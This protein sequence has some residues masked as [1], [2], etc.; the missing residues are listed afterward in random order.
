MD[1]NFDEVIDGLEKIEIKDNDYI[2]YDTLENSSENLK[3]KKISYKG[4][5]KEIPISNPDPANCEEFIIS[6]MRYCKFVKLKNCEFCIYHIPDE[7]K[8]MLIDCPIDPS[9]RI[10]ISNLKKHSKICNKLEQK[11]KLTNSEW[12]SEKINKVDHSAFGI[13]QNELNELYELRWEEIQED[14]YSK[15][16]DKIIKC[17]EI[18]KEDYYNYSKKEN[19]SSDI[20]SKYETYQSVTKLGTDPSSKA[21]DCAEYDYL[22]SLSG[23]EVND[24]KD[25][26]STK[27]LVKS[28]KNGKQNAAIGNLLQKYNLIDLKNVYIEFGAGRGGLSEYI[29]KML[30]H[31][32]VH[33]LLER[34]G[35]RFKKDR[36]YENMIRVSFKI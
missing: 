35:V 33:I 30:N 7:N 34:E 32:S 4:K 11:A 20:I 17:Y 13:D 1:K 5:I 27:N 10:L 19:L 29:G 9:H 12:Y 2:K 22:V 26:N 3:T 14:E 21:H 18:L 15:M 31:K 25:L 8:E 16:I 36:F 24:L 23:L 28:E 6:R